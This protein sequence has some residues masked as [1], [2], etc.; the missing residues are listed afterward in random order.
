MH[1]LLT[2]SAYP[3]SYPLAAN[4]RRLELT[5]HV[6]ARSLAAQT[7]RRWR[8]VV[9]IDPADPLLE[10]RQAV[11]AGAGV[12]VI[13]VPI[14]QVRDTDEIVPDGRLVADVDAPGR[15]WRR[16]IAADAPAGRVVT[17]R[18]DDDDA[19]ATD[20]LARIRSHLGEPDGPTAWVM[21]SGYKWHKGR[22]AAMSHPSNMFAT[23]DAP[24]ELRTVMDVKHGV[25]RRYWPVRMVDRSPGWL[26]VRHADTR[27]G[28]RNAARA[29]SSSVADRFAV[30]W[31]YLRGVA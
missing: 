14:H 9:V 19:L 26:W 7:E 18:L 3:A 13:A 15:I 31:A 30:D 4:R 28:A 22:V 16:A 25:L 27:S 8:W 2:R 20:A 24:D 11:L 21:P 10:E 17:T 5:R 23:L 29:L 6:T 12:P 1:Y